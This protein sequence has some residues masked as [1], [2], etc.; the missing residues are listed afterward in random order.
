MSKLPISKVTLPAALVGVANG[1][2]DTDTLEACDIPGVKLEATA[3]RAW[4]ALNAAAAARGFKLRTTGAYRSYDAQVELFLS[5]YVTKELAGRPTKTWNGVKYWQ[6]PNTAM[7]ATPG[8]SNH[9]LGLAIDLAEEN[10]GDKGVEFVSP[11]LVLWLRDNAHLYGISAE[12]NSEVWHWRYH[13]GDAIPAAVLEYENGSKTAPEASQTPVQ[14]PK[15]SKASLRRGSTGEAVKRLQRSLVAE[16]FGVRGGIDGI[17]G[18]YTEGAVKRYQ[19][20][21]GLLADGVA[22]PATLGRLGL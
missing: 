21:E 17:Y 7:A 10:D 19:V 15:P 4:R 5:R 16:G 11:M 6:K 2:L 20:R 9:G 12:D 8:T 1:K 22:G 3:A 14:A 18:K 13:A